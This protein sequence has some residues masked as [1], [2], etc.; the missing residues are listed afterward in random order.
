M[1]EQSRQPK[2]TPMIT[3]HRPG[4]RDNDPSR[5]TAPTTVAWPVADRVPVTVTTEGKSWRDGYTIHH[6][7]AIVAP[8]IAHIPIALPDSLSSVVVAAERALAELD[9]RLAASDAAVIEATTF[10]L[11]RSES[12][13]SSRIEGINVT[14]RRVAEA[15]Q[16]A[17]SAK[18]LAREVVGNIDAMQSALAYGSAADPFTPDD[19]LDLHRRLMA[20]A[21]GI[22]EGEYRTEQNWIGA[23]H[24]EDGVAYVPP[25]PDTI[26]G[27]MG[28]L[29]DFINTSPTTSVVRAAIA[30]AQFEAVHPFVDGNG[31]VGRCI[32]SITMRKAGGTTTIPPVS[33]VLLTDTDGYFA[34]LHEFQQN[35][36]PG[37]WIGQFA[38][39]TIVACS[40]A[41]ALVADIEE[42]KTDWRRRTGARNGSH[43]IRLIDALPMLTLATADQVA[44]RL[45]IDANQARRLLGQ[46]EHAGIAKQAS[47]GRR[48]RVWRIDQMFRLLDDHSLA[49]T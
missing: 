10:A 14:H 7:D 39:A 11:L 49:R 47:D 29:C 25:P 17:D 23:E 43:L 20:R 13:S 32:V 44:D 35:A 12:V 28:D 24:V 19:I 8:C 48:N 36:N 26:R 6:L 5:A 16:D 42:L 22:K 34:A 40:R 31:R 37:P 46:L 4:L 15:I 9:A 30:H 18:H 33:S 3:G 2:G 21:I 38:N 41:K 1:T 45:E 27:L